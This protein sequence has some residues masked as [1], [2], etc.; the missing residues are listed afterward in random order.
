MP[1]TYSC[2]V[3]QVA[4]PGHVRITDEWTI[5]KNFCEKSAVLKMPGKGKLSMDCM[6][7]FDDKTPF[8]YMGKAKELAHDKANKAKAS[9]ALEEVQGAADLVAAAARIEHAVSAD[10]DRGCG[11][12]RRSRARGP[13]AWSQAWRRR[14]RGLQQPLLLLEG[15]FRRFRLFS[16]SCTGASLLGFFRKAAQELYPLAFLGKLHRSFTLF[17]AACSTVPS[18]WG[19]TMLQCIGAC[20]QK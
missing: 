2:L 12:K 10:A 5:E 17:F 8:N 7:L 9:G 14:G 15:P 13:L 3:H 1:C 11:K 20:G 18:A 4:L 19:E 16:D 6:D